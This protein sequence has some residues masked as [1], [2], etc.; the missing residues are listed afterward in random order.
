MVVHS[1]STMFIIPVALMLLTL[2]V[3]GTY[4]MLS[5]TGMGGPDFKKPDEPKDPLP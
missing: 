2:F 5:R 4:L 3:V 1:G